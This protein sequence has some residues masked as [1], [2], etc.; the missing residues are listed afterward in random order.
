MRTII[1]KRLGIGFAA[2]PLCG[3]LQIYSKSLDLGL[4]PGSFERKPKIKRLT[5]KI[6]VVYTRIFNVNMDWVLE[7]S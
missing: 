3:H 1:L 7:F 6:T 4:R 2:V 5:K